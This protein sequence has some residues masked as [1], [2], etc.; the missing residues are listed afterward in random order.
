MKEKLYIEYY[1]SLDAIY[2]GILLLTVLFFMEVRRFYSE[3]SI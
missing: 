2:S 3:K 1:N